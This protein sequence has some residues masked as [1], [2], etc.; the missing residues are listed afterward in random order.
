M[1]NIQILIFL[2]C[3]VLCFNSCEL[4]NYEGPTGSISG[5][6]IDSETGELVQGDIISG[7]QIEYMELDYDTVNPPIQR[8]VVKVDGTYRNDMMFQGRYT[9]LPLTR[10]NFVP[11]TDTLTI[12]IGGATIQNFEVLP[13]IRIKDASITIDG[14]KIT[15]TFKL[16]QTVE[17]KIKY[18]GL[19][20]HSS[21]AVGEP[22]QFGK[23]RK[24]LNK[25]ADPDTE[26]ELVM[27]VRSDKDF[28]KGKAY[29]FRIGALISAGE[30][31]YNYAPAVRLTIPL[32]E[33]G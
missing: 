33:E 14:T 16:E 26:Y 12:D 21:P 5:A 13:Y 30:A 29:F 18:I 28:E 22:L 2:L 9:I 15:A 7:T 25:V 24:T 3:G 19:F 1:K 27:D 17:D 20:G 32:P 23:K 8:L 4:D 11:Q 6:L 10:G 31:E